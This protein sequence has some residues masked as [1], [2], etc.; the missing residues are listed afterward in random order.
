MPD[1]DPWYIKLLER[2]GVNTTKLRWRL[3]QQEQQ[4]KRLLEEGRHPTAFQWLRYPNKI[5]PHCR[6][7]NDRHNRTCDSCG[8]RLPTMFGYRLRRLFN[9]IL[10]AD[11]ASVSMVFFTLMFAFFLAELAMDGFGLRSLLN[12]SMN[13][14]YILGA[15]IPGSTQGGG[16]LWRGLAF[17]LV[18]SGIIHIGL[19]AYA[20]LQIGPMTESQLSR[21]RMLV[22]ITVGQ[23]AS[24]IGCYVW[25]YRLQG[26]YVPI[27]GASGMLFALIGYGILYAHQM[28]PQMH[29]L[30]NALI[31]WAV[32][33]LLLSFVLNLYGGGVISNAAH[34]GGLL[35]GLA[36]ALV[37]ESRARHIRAWDAG[38]MAAGW[39]CALM[40]V[41]TIALAIRSIVVLWPHVAGQ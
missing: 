8:R 34:I 40:W 32:V 21:S 38:W 4:A 17:M 11:A 14:L 22:L 19:N 2:L 31:R 9:M 6:A 39:V 27:V 36:F 35:G 23:I 28:G 30:R 3:Y 15:Y 25:Y 26:A 12:P 16:A 18:H 20:F 24:A 5:C 29:P 7:I 41:A 1:A 37:P 10:P 33:L 13:T